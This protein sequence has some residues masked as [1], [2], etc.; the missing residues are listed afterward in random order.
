MT[1]PE[2]VQL[3]LQSAAIGQDGE[4]LVLDMGEPVRIADVAA[5]LIR[6]SGRDIPILFTG[7]RAGEKLDED[8][9]ARDEVGER[10]C[11]ELIYHVPAP[12]LQPSSVDAVDVSARHHELIESLRD[13]AESP[14]HASMH[15][16]LRAVSG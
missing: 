5:H 8:L 11:H 6:Q 9:F 16:V 3:V 10:R 2:A 7:M 12:P 13:L 14:S 15:G 1:I 4:I